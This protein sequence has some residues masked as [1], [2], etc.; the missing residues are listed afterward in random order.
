MPTF[1]NSLALP[2]S[3][4]LW[5]W[6]RQRV[7]KRWHL[8][9]RHRGTTQKNTHDIQNKKTILNQEA[10]SLSKH[11]IKVNSGICRRNEVSGGVKSTNSSTSS[12]VTTWVELYS[13]CLLPVPMLLHEWSCTVAVFYQFRCSYKNGAVQLVYSCCKVAV[14]LLYSR[15]TVAVQSLYSWCTVAVQLVYSCLKLLYS[16]CT[17]SVQLLSST[18]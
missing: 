12:E 17:V 8:N 11:A 18:H 2:S 7:P 10:V 14:Q 13:C 4:R 3:S 9:Y 15:C 16:C 5:I 1:R 6:N